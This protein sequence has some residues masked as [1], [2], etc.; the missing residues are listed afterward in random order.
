MSAVQS[1]TQTCLHSN[2]DKITLSKKEKKIIFLEKL[3]HF[4]F[5]AT[6]YRERQQYWQYADDL[7][8]EDSTIVYAGLRFV[9]RQEHLF[10]QCFGTFS[11]S[12]FPFNFFQWK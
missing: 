1:G 3:A 4:Q 2:T 6:D 12:S 7:E 10:P 8:T 11:I 5:S 9:S